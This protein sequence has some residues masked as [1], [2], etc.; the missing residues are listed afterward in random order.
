[1]HSPYPEPILASDQMSTDM[2]TVGAFSRLIQSPL[3]CDAG[4]IDKGGGELEP[5]LQKLSWLVGLLLWGALAV[6][7]I[8]QE[9]RSLPLRAATRASVLAVDD[10]STS[11]FQYRYL[12]GDR[13]C[14]GEAPSD[15]PIPAP[16][17]EVWIHY[18]PKNVCHSVAYDPVGHLVGAVIGV[19]SMSAL[20]AFIAWNYWPPKGR[21][22]PP[23]RRVRLHGLLRLCPTHPRVRSSVSRPSSAHGLGGHLAGHGSPGPSHSD[24]GRGC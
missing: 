17:T 9:S 24:N 10:P 4:A 11:S 8:L 15:K 6:G 16:E 12:V 1:M 5:R 21:N 3:G 18:D 20:L 7:F 13:V 14:R 2:S 23:P 22:E 19:A